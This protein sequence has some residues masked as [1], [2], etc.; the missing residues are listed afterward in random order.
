MLT[1]VP[2][3]IGNLQDITLRALDTFK[4]A[5]IIFCE[6]TRVT[7]QLLTLLEQNYHLQCSA[8]LISF[9][10]HNQ[11]QRLK[12]FEKSMFEKNIVYVSDAGMPAIS[13]PGAKLAQYAIENEIDYDVLPGANAAITAFA[14]SGFEGKFLFYG[15]LPKEKRNKELQKIMHSNYFMILYEAP[16]RIEKL[17]KEIMSFDA[18]REVFL[19]KEISKKFQTFYKGKIKDINLQNTKG[20]WVV[21][22][23]PAKTSTIELSI[24]EVLELKVP[25][26]L[27]SKL[28][29]KSGQKSA[30]EWYNAL[31]NNEL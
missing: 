10:E 11:N 13:D 5:D 4:S 14:A 28:L 9:H 22:L 18:H 12:S 19:A 29:A 27:K 21:I 30:K 1:F 23:S 26:K 17:L 7:K 8:E 25:D 3:P 20:E 16:H 24:E 6:D 31:I 2:T 15:F